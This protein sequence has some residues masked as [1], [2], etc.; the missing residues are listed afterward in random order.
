MIKEAEV[1][2]FNHL[3]V[4]I[5]S[6][7]GS[8]SDTCKT[9]APTTQSTITFY[10]PFSSTH[11]EQIEG[12]RT[13]EDRVTAVVHG[14]VVDELHDHHGLAHPGTSEQADLATLTRPHII[15]VIK[16]FQHIQY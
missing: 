13:C 2:S 10:T 9:T 12:Q 3:V 6:F 8:L 11:C 15:Y 1:T 5:V 4:Q 7:T 16:S 14:D